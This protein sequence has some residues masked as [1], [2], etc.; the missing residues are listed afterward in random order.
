MILR[1]MD[2]Y[3]QKKM[4]DSLLEKCWRH[5]QK[6]G[7]DA[8]RQNGEYAEKLYKCFYIEKMRP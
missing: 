1:K 5:T 7:G 2:K 8:F 4:L 6:I 3:L